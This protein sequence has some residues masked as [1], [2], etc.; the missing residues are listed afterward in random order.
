MLQFPV[1][2]DGALG[3]QQVAWPATAAFD[4]LDGIVLDEDHE[5]YV[6]HYV[7]GHVTRPADSQR[8]AELKE[9]RSLAFRDGTL[10]VTGADRL[11][12]V[13]LGIC[14]LP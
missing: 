14:G 1:A 7:Q 2:E 11:F 8:V 4:A 3:A 10:L 13:D 12:A 9:P 6:A 5:I